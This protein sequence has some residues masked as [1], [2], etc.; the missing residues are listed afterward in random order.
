MGFTIAEGR[1]Q[2][3]LNGFTIDDQ[4]HAPTFEPVGVAHMDVVDRAAKGAFDAR[5]KNGNLVAIH[6]EGKASEEFPLNIQSAAFPL[7]VKWTVSNTTKKYSL[8]VGTSQKALAGS[9]ET[10]IASANQSVKLKVTDKVLPET[11]SL[12]QNY[13]NPFNPTTTISFSLPVQSVI[14]LRIYNQ[15]G[16][17]VQTVQDQ[18]Q[19]DAGFYNITVDAS[20]LASGVYY[21]RI[22]AQANGGNSE[23]QFHNVKSLMIVK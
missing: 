10:K 1:Q 21:Y 15:L 17:V 3:A 6:S 20:A 12:G 8:L 11:Y 2:I 23:T 4:F 5:F 18:A 22:D 9:G 13:P 7:T 14:S 16:Q 19:L